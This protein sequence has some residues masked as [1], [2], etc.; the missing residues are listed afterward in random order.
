DD[1]A[2]AA[3]WGGEA[4]VAALGEL[5]LAGGEV[6]RGGLVRTPL[7]PVVCFA[8]IGPGE[9]LLGGRKVVGISQ[10]RTRN[11]A[12][13]QCSVPLRWDAALHAALLAPGIA[14]VC[15]GADPVRAVSELPVLPLVDVDADVTVDVLLAH[16]P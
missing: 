14:R 11:G 2:G 16:L 1:V 12:R 6:H 7:A 8:G 9:V 4:G 5:G 13:F 10:R 3:E 15:P